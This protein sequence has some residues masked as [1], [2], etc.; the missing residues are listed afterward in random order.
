M[1]SLRRYV[2][3]PS[4]ASVE[5]R[6]LNYLRRGQCTIGGWMVMNGTCVTSIAAIALKQI[7]QA[8]YNR[9]E[10]KFASHILF[11][12]QGE[13]FLQALNMHKRWRSDEQP[14]LGQFTLV[15]S[16]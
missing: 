14:R 2:G 11:E 12:R 16:R 7:V 8:Q 10:L 1:A 15:G 4:R 9:E 3:A 6:E 13:L 5:K